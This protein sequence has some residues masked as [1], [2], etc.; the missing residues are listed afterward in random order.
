MF[1]NIG[2]DL[3]TEQ[4]IKYCKPGLGRLMRAFRLNASYSHA[5]GGRLRLSESSNSE[6][7]VIDLV[8]SYGATLLGHNYPEIIEE[9]RFLLQQKLPQFIQGSIHHGSTVLAEKLNEAA[10]S[11]LGSD[12]C[13]SFF[14]TGSEAVEAAVKHIFLLRNTKLEALRES[15]LLKS[16]N[17]L[18]KFSRL[19]R[20]TLIKHLLPSQ[21]FSPE[22][23]VAQEFSDSPEHDTE[24]LRCLDQY[25]LSRQ[26]QCVRLLAFENAYHGQTLGA[27]G[28]TYNERYR[29]P[30]QNLT[31]DVIFIKPDISEFSEL[32]E[33]EVTSFAL[34]SCKSGNLF[35]E[36]IPVSKLVGLFFE[37]VQGEGGAIPLFDKET[38]EILNICRKKELPLIADEIQ[39]GMG[40]TGKI[41]AWEH[42]EI[43]G[44][45]FILLGKFLGGGLLKISAVMSK[46][47]VLQEEFGLIHHSTFAE[48]E[49]SSLIGIKTLELLLENDG[50]V[51][52]RVSSAGKIWKEKLTSVAVKFPD[53]IKEIRGCGLLLGIE[54]IDFFDSDSH[55]LRFIC[56]QGD[57]GYAVAGFLLNE[58]GIRVS[59]TLNSKL[60]VRVEPSVGF[61]TEDI[62]YVCQALEILCDILR[63]RDMASMFRFLIQDVVASENSQADPF[64]R[65]KINDFQR[66]VSD[67]RQKIEPAENK[68]AFL[69]HFINPLFLARHEPSL[70]R[71]SFEELRQFI[72]RTWEFIDPCIFVNRDI[73]SGTGAKVNFNFV[74]LS[75]TSEILIDLFKRRQLSG[76]RKLVKRA[77]E[78]ARDA[79]CRM[80]GF[81]QFTSIITRNC[82]ELSVPPV[83]F[84][85]GNSLTIGMSLNALNEALSKKGK[86]LENVRTAVL[87]AGGNIGATFSQLI[88]DRAER[89]VLIGGNS[90]D[91]QRSLFRT[92]GLIITDQIRSVNDC[93][94]NV[95]KSSGIIGDWISK[96]FSEPEYSHLI[97]TILDDTWSQDASHLE[98][99]NFCIKLGSLLFNRMTSVS[100]LTV[101]QS[102]DALKDCEAIV[103]STNSTEPIVFPQHISPDTVICDISVPSSVSK[104]ALQVEGVEIFKGGVVKLPNAERLNIDALPLEPGLVYSCMA[105]TILLGLEKHWN[106]YSVGDISKKQVLDILK[107]AEKHNFTLARPKIEDAF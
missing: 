50:E 22:R 74:G 17:V 87:G 82:L 30:F 84:T 2:N 68:V 99:D 16:S 45:D 6:D 19:D 33:R 105:E 24:I 76:A 71:F 27:L 77:L 13:T 38:R 75:V 89:L 98:R 62:D 95:A 12:Y 83:A 35:L 104:D 55:L 66:N 56:V 100:P 32:I 3:L 18:R 64:T 26:V 47:E 58:F 20:S 69:G 42:L 59:P 67:F 88:A 29:C 91:S 25:N 103:T 11:R 54:F 5:F 39:S 101:A 106:D 31:P 21:V 48:D 61:S 40:R 73:V 8:G 14:N 79:G 94:S 57:F 53:V 44:P 52:N 93:N 63:K 86:K 1:I 72:G 9:A 49:L 43:P 7:S 10:F 46:R 28:M 80:A 96:I 70:N 90:S 4:Y 15:L 41:F 37:P 81:G 78:V 34:I 107:I 97:R 51:L 65:F 60:T 92:L 102:P 23:P 85:S 36:H